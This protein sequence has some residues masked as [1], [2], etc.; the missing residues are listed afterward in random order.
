MCLFFRPDRLY[1]WRCLALCEGSSTDSFPV[2]MCW[3]RSV[4]PVAYSYKV[5]GFSTLRRGRLVT[6]VILQHACMS[7]HNPRIISVVVGGGDYFSSSGSID[8]HILRHQFLE[9][10]N[11]VFD[12]SLFARIVYSTYMISPALAKCPSVQL[13]VGLNTCFMLE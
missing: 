1:Y 13:A 8:I 10:W 6:K 2:Y 5:K 7:L 9:I 4:P 12:I 11:K 3:L